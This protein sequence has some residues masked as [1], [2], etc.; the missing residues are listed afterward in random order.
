MN[1]V[2]GIIHPEMKIL[3]LFTHPHIVLNLHELLSSVEHKKY[4]VVITIDSS[5]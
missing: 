2:K 4:M 3:S 1:V 5:H